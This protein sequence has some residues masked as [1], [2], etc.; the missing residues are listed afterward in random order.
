MTEDDKDVVTRP[1]RSN[2]KKTGWGDKPDK[3]NHGKKTSFKRRLAEIEDDE[4]DIR[5]Y[6]TR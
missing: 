3:I 2:H 5:D 4:D 6:I 1:K